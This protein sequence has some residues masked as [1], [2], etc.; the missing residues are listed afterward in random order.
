MNQN[1]AADTR[2]VHYS[3]NSPGCMLYGLVKTRLICYV[4]KMRMFTRI[5]IRI[6]PVVTSAHPHIHI[7][8]SAVR[9]WGA[10]CCIITVQTTSHRAC[11]RE[12]AHTVH[13]YVL[14]Q[15]PDRIR[16]QCGTCCC[17]DSLR[18]TVSCGSFY[19]PPGVSTDYM[20]DM[21][22]AIINLCTHAT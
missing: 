7:I 2:D 4:D 21:N 19:H 16:L 13:L 12:L 20:D 17:Q 10:L 8:P 11:T 5:G 18:Q 6:I 14:D 15:P 1:T 3:L 9:P 22:Q